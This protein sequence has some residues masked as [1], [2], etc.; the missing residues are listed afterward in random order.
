VRRPPS[1]MDKVRWIAAHPDLP[2]PLKRNGTL[3]LPQSHRCRCIHLPFDHSNAES[4]G[5]ALRGPCKASGCE[6]RGL[7]LDPEY[8][9]DKEDPSYLE[10]QERV[11]LE[12]PTPRRREMTEEEAQ[13]AALERMNADLKR[14]PQIQRF[15]VFE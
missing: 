2:L 11:R 4:D 8:I 7:D 1:P 15:G 5:G 12:C 13:T 9:L 14:A 10:L 6:C 3:K